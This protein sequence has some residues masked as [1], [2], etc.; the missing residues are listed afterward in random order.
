[1]KTQRLKGG[2]RRRNHLGFSTRMELHDQMIL[3]HQE[4]STDAGAV[5]LKKDGVYHLNTDRHAGLDWINGS[6]HFQFALMIDGVKV[7]PNMW[8]ASAS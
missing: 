4:V 6:G 3:A 7:G 8:K 2:D 5:V 1:M